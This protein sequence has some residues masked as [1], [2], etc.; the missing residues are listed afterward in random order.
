MQFGLSCLVVDVAERLE[1]V[2]FKGREL[3]ED[4]AISSELFEVDVTLPVEVCAHFFNLEIG[5]IAKSAAECALM[6]ARS[7]EAEP[8]DE[9]SLRE[10]LAG[11][12]YD[13]CET[14][15]LSMYTCDVCAACNP[16]V[17][18]VLVSL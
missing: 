5:H 4:T 9:S 1:A 11:G 14:Y 6:G 2:N 18:L 7:T 10:H 13:F 17:R 12:A 3:N 16:D 15:V 8:F